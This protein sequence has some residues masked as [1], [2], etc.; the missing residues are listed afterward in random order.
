MFS[1]PLNP[2]LNPSQF[3]TFL[4]FLKEHRDLIYDVYF[5]SRIPPFEFDAMGD[6]YKESQFD[7]L[8]ENALIITKQTGIPLSA[9]LNNIEVPPTMENLDLLIKNYKKLYDAGVKIV[10]IPHT[11][12]ML[13]GKFQK[14]YPD[15]LIKNTILRNVQR[16][17]EVVKCVEAGFHYINFDR[18]LMR[19]EDML[20]RMQDAKKHCKEKLGVDVKF[21][22][23]ANEGCW[24]NCPVQD[25]HF[26]Y[27]NTRKS[28][29]DPTYFMQPISY[30][31][32][33][34]WEE[35]DPASM[36]RIANF[37]PWKEE[38]DRLL[39]YIDVIKMHG[40][41]SVSRLFETMNIIS[42]YKK[43]EEILFPEYEE[44]IKLNKFPQ[45]RIDV[46]RK[47][48]RNC[49]FDCWDC[50]VCDKIV[51]ANTKLGFSIVTYAGNSTN[52][53]TY[54]HGLSAKP[55]FSLTKVRNKSGESWIAYH[56][57]MGY[58]KFGRLNT[59]GLFET[60]NTTRF[61][62]EPTASLVYLGTD[63]STNTGYN[64][65]SY[66]WHN[67][68]GMQH[69]RSY[70]ANASDDGPFI[71]TGF[72]PR[73]LFVKNVD[74]NS[75]EWEVR[76]TAVNTFNPAN[77]GIYWDQDQAEATR[78]EKYDILSNGFKIRTNGGPG[79]YNSGSTIIFGA[80]A[81][82]PYKYNNTF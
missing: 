71:Y 27:N 16:P 1:V 30:F 11:L 13:T 51:Q 14:A 38:W 7:L 17:N 34:S 72:R 62:Q 76:D 20:K 79:N 57:S 66:I 65:V 37:P 82:V 41:E 22:L 77:K 44:H 59:N 28:M 6:V 49:K 74:E 21:S 12:W 5:T 40:R 64:Y 78:S 75:T 24:G 4:K 15:V 2:K 23:L 26:L 58:N 68:E 48:I 3:D 36:W 29:L 18:D 31:S 60:N 39:T 32:C 81:D 50:N 52:G 35:K 10:T 42:R 73:M 56:S 47:T 43:G 19:D 69:F 46:W 67:V 33:P 25:E 8:T 53:A 61:S 9:T 63:P 80:W 54:G 45:K 55:D 70:T